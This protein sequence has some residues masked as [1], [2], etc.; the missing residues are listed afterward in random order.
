MRSGF[1]FHD[2]V[3]AR[4][5][6]VK[7]KPERRVNPRKKQELKKMNLKEILPRASLED[8]ESLKE[9]HRALEREGYADKE[10]EWIHHPDNVKLVIESE[11]KSCL[12]HALTLAMGTHG[13]KATA[14]CR[15]VWAPILEH[16]TCLLSPD[17][18]AAHPRQIL[19]TLVFF[20]Y[21]PGEFKYGEVKPIQ[22]TRDPETVTDIVMEWLDSVF[23]SQEGLPPKMLEFRNYDGTVAKGWKVFTEQ[24]GHVGEC[25]YAPFA[26]Q[27]SWAYYGK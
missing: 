21:D 24:W 7:F 25:F 1:L 2:L 17:N 11:G 15:A 19:K 12:R 10:R 16:R 9:L 5:F 6:L 18:P 14:E 3:M 4:V 13:V 23:D 8:R 27:P 22:D 26:V 20:W